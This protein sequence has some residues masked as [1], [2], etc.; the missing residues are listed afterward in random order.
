M[1][2]VLYIDY[3]SGKAS[4]PYAYR[5]LNAKNLGEAIL[6]ADMWYDPRNVYL[7]RIMVKDG[8]VEHPERGVSAQR[9]TSRYEKR[10]F[11]WRVYDETVHTVKQVK[12]RHNAW[13]E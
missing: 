3:L 11:N 8:A 10:S 1:K 4:K 9:Y 12:M 7:V 5:A 13:F 2:Y 6:E